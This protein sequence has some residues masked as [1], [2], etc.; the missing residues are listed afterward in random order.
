MAHFQKYIIDYIMF[1]ILNYLLGDLL[2]LMKETS[3]NSHHLLHYLEQPHY[4]SLLSISLKQKHKITS[5]VREP[6]L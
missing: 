3:Q 5:S 6:F 2:L 1:T 4:K